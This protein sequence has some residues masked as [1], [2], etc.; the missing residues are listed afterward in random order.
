MTDERRDPPD[1]AGLLREAMADPTATPPGVPPAPSIEELAP[2]FPEFEIHEIVGRGGMGAVY[3]ATHR[4]LERPVAIK[5]LLREF[6]KDPEFGER[7][8]REARALASLR[9]P[10]ILVVHDFGERDGLFFLVSEFVEGVDLRKLMALGELSPAEALRIAPQICTALQYA[11]EHGVVHR[12]IKPENI[13]IDVDGQVKIADFGMAKV[14]RPGDPVALT[15]DTAV[16]GTPHYMAPEQ[17]RGSARVDHRA[18]IYSLGVVLYEMLTGELPLGHFDPPSVRRGGVPRGLDEVVRRA[19]AQQPEKR[20]QQVSEVKTDVERHAREAEGPSIAKAQR[21]R[22]LDHLAAGNHYRGDARDLANTMKSRWFA[23]AAIALV[24]L[25]VLSVASPRGSSLGL[26]LQ[27][28]ALLVVLAGTVA[29]ISDARNAREA[30]RR[31][32]RATRHG[33]RPTSSRERSATRAEREERS[34]DPESGATRTGADAPRP[35][36]APWVAFAVAVVGLIGSKAA[37]LTAAHAAAQRWIFATQLEHY[38]NLMKGVFAASRERGAT[39]VPPDGF[40]LPEVP[41]T[42]AWLATIAPFVAYA[43]LASTALAVLALGV[44]SLASVRNDSARWSGV[45]P[46]VVATWIVPLGLVASIAVVSVGAMRDGDLQILA[47]LVLGLLG[48]AAAVVFLVWETRRQSRLVAA[49]IPW[50]SG[51]PL[52][53]AATVLTAVS[54]VTTLTLPLWVSPSETESIEIRPGMTRPA[55]LL[56]RSRTFVLARLGP[57]S[58]I[59]TSRD[60]QTWGYRNTRTDGVVEDALEFAGTRVVSHTS[61]T[62]LLGYN[63]WRTDGPNLGQSVEDLVRAY[64]APTGRAQG[65]LTVEMAFAN[66]V[67]ISA[68]DGIVVGIHD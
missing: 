42:S 56:G 29:A 1:H 50:P 49:G 65:A 34:D 22:D 37:A 58:S 15:R 53:T 41:D 6:G 43:I 63:S 66:G 54:L 14:L 67:R 24:V 31:R 51:R 44:W 4:T 45:G 26:L 11:H 3:R 20:Y 46:A 9:H 18:D 57:P 36:R 17:W 68:K 27:A 61:R 2:L 52:Q 60:G 55:D 64:G 47:G 12:D 23:V 19:L 35:V 16:F 10:G 39:W 5:V 13:L 8:L 30:L 25:L 7:F 21:R 59:T 32:L 48:M 40:G 28:G 33:H 38:D 62:D